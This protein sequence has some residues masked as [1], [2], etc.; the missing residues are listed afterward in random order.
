MPAIDKVADDRQ[1]TSAR[2]GEAV[3]P[4]DTNELTAVSR[5]LWIGVA[6]NVVVVTANGTTLTLKGASAG[7][8]IP[9]RVKQVRATNTTATDIVALY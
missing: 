3:T 8:V 1:M 6:G 4:H 9:I 2:D 5:A 7:Q